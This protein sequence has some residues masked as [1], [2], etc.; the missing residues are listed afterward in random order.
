MTENYDS[1]SDRQS[2]LE[3]IKRLNQEI[4][5]LSIENE[6]LQIALL[7]TAEHGDII[8]AQLEESNRKL[9]EEINE[10]KRA[11]SS[12]QA[13]LDVVSRQKEDLEILIEILTE[14]GDV[15]HNELFEKMMKANQLAGTD[16]LT[17]LSNR[18][19]FEDYLKQQWQKMMKAKLPLTIMICDID[20]FKQYNDTYGHLAGDNCLQKVANVFREVVTP[21]FGLISRYGGEE[22]AGIFPNRNETEAISLSEKIQEKIREMKV[23]HTNSQV[24]DYITLSIGITSVIPSPEITPEIVLDQADRLLYLAKH[25]GRN[26]I[27]VSSQ[28][29]EQKLTLS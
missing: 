13:V 25:Q 26:Q 4:E 21:E 22:F 27:V 20:Y 5:R 6:D 28:I 15:I 29:P 16:P 10:R 17:Q 8:E 19:S 3:E 14:H 7:T 1:D 12:L 18:R 9:K 2:M 24:S 23:S 11:E